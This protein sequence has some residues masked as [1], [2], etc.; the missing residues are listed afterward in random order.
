MLGILRKSALPLK[1]QLRIVIDLYRRGERTG[2]MTL[3]Q[4]SLGDGAN[5]CPKGTYELIIEK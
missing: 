5:S 1:H 2:S 3:W 4:P